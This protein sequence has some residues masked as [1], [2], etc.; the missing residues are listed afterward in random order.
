M[1]NV[2]PTGY[3]SGLCLYQRAVTIVSE[4]HFRKCIL[5]WR[6]WWH[7]SV[8]YTEQINTSLPCGDQNVIDLRLEYIFVWFHSSPLVTLWHLETAKEAWFLYKRMI[9]KQIII[10]SDCTFSSLYIKMQSRSTVKDFRYKWV[11]RC[12]KTW[13]IINT[14]NMLMAALCSVSSHLQG[15]NLYFTI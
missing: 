11:S 13:G 1:V 12:F 6:W 5:C 4:Q 7:D 10:F 9:L 3:S 8:F 14:L 15:F 2:D